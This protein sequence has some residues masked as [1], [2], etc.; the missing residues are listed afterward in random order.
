MKNFTF[1]GAAIT[2]FA[3]LLMGRIAGKYQL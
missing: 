3:G 1:I 2:K